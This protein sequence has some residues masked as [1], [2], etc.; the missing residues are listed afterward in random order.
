M[1]PD[2]YDYTKL[3]TCGK[4]FEQY[5][6]SVFADLGYGVDVTP[7]VGD[8]GADVILTE[9]DSGRRIA[10]QA[11]F[12]NGHRLGNAP[13]QEVAGSLAHYGACEG[14][15]VTNGTFSDAAHT[16]AEEN[17][18]R[19]IDGPEL[20]GLV[21]AAIDNRQRADVAGGDGIPWRRLDLSGLEVMPEGPILGD[22]SRRPELIYEGYPVSQCPSERD[23]TGLDSSS[24]VGSYGAT[25]A[26]EPPSSEPLPASREQ[27]GSWRDRVMNLSDVA[28]RWGVSTERVKREIPHGLPIFKQ[29]NGRWEILAGDLVDWE[30]RKESREVRKA[31]LRA[32]SA[33]AQRRRHAIA[34]AVS[35]LLSIVVVVAIVLVALWLVPDLPSQLMDVLRQLV[36]LAK[37][38][39]RGLGIGDAVV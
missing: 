5:V 17:D 28:V 4:D 8:Y 26:W 38:A 18:V 12:Y 23:R 16:L 24:A 34:S 27:S 9:P 13:V 37:N 7:L 21:A 15:V 30:E 11:K 14:W 2:H 32:Q 22:E 25:R 19:L 1:T 10:V 33:H 35:F 20:N 3:P 29:P 31:E 39:V 36:A 6:G